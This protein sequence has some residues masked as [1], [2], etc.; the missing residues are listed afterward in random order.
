MMEI[1]SSDIKNKF[2]LLEKL[3]ELYIQGFFSETEI[4]LYVKFLIIL[5]SKKTNILRFSYLLL[6]M[7][8]RRKNDK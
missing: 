2:F 4:L 1:S 3:T 7:I 6:D 5:G 8:T